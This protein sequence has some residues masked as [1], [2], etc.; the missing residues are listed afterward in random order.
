[1]R[2][3]KALYE[4]NDAHRHDKEDCEDEKSNKFRELYL[5]IEK[6]TVSLMFPLYPKLSRANS[7]GNQAKVTNSTRI[8]IISAVRIQIL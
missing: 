1:M 8:S 5:K 6:L 7:T 4:R 3:F 2:E